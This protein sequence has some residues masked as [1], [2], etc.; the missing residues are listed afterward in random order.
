M[1]SWD[2]TSIELPNALS[3]SNELMIW[4]GVASTRMID[5]R[6]FGLSVTDCAA[7]VP[8]SATEGKIRVTI[9]VHFSN[10]RALTL[11]QLTLRHA[12]LTASTITAS[13]QCNPSRALNLT[14]V[15]SSTQPAFSGCE[16]V[17]IGA[18]AVSPRRVCGQN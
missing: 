16:N 5:D 8:L 13:M 10:F 17:I 2:R 12:L 3:G 11:V 18:V 6:A 1:P 7:A 9:A 4:P 15:K 14:N